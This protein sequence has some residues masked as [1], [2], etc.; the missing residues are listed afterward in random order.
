MQSRPDKLPH[1]FPS[2]CLQ[3]PKTGAMVAATRC[4]CIQGDAAITALAAVSDKLVATTLA[5]SIAVFARAAAHTAGQNAAGVGAPQQHN[6]WVAQSSLAVDAAVT[7]LQVDSAGQQAVV[8]T[9][10][11]TVW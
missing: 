5:G 4:C 1:L 7:S 8:G 2:L 6:E 10:A 9:A 3:I 11:C